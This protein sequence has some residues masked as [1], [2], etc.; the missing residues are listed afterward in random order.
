MTP[1]GT[2]KENAMR[3][4]EVQQADGHHSGAP[5][6]PVRRTHRR[7]RDRP[8]HPP[9]G[10]HVVVPCS[11]P[12]TDTARVNRPKAK[13][14]VAKES[15]AVRSSEPSAHSSDPEG[16]RD[17][18]GDRAGMDDPRRGRAG[19]RR[20]RRGHHRRVQHGG[21][22]LRYFD[23]LSMNWVLENLTEAGGFLLGWR[24]YE[25]FASHWPNAS[26]M[27]SRSPPVI[28]GKHRADRIPGAL[29]PLGDHRGST[30]TLRIVAASPTTTPRSGPAY[31]HG[32]LK[33][34]LRPM[35][36]QAGPQR[37]GGRR[38]P[39]ALAEHSPWP[40]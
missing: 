29:P 10:E 16:D 13:A 8:R 2:T 7:G 33:A 31:D 1:V 9:R 14:T 39:C 32:R 12:W 21:W 25:G 22:H 36:A 28:I 5:G 11:A 15:A 23:D 27:G 6:A 26:E 3:V 30:T 24:T 40:L 38:R 34:R 19:P 18:Q 37:Q 35:L 20:H 17:A 4:L